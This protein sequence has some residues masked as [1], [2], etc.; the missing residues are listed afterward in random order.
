MGRHSG[1]PRYRLHKRSGRALVSFPEPFKGKKEHYLGVF[2]TRQTSPESWEKYDRLISEW[3]LSKHDPR[4][5]MELARGDVV[6]VNR[7]VDAYLTHAEAHYRKRG[8]VTDQYHRIE[9]AVRP[10]IALYGSTP[11]A[12]FGKDQLAAVRQRM[13]DQDW[14]RGFINSCIGCLK[15][16]FDWGCPKLVPSSVAH[17]LRGFKPLRKNAPGVRETKKIRPVPIDHVQKTLAFL[18]PIVADM[19]RVQLLAD[20]RPCEVCG[21]RR[22]DINFA[23]FVEDVGRFPGVWAYEVSD[24][25]NKNAHRDQRRIVLFGPQAMKVLKKYL[26]GRATD[27]YLFSPRESAQWFCREAGRAYRPGR[28]REPGLKYTTDTYGNAIER[29]CKRAG[30]PRWAPNRLRKSKA[31]EVLA[32]YG[33]L[34]VQ[35]ML[36]HAGLDIVTTYA[37]RDLSRVAEVMKKIG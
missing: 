9:S 1:H 27:A 3:L 28:E 35:A 21:L 29:A 31:T 34:E 2:G 17:E 18:P 6:S 36:G 4:A 33:P 20:M 22:C 32:K 11:A 37:F 8:K 5:G 13:A 24:D 26:K 30:V 10:L 15:T 14:S 16:M 19:V 7:L 23:G 12:E 25:S